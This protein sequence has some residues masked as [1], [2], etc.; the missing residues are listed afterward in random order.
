[1]EGLRV[2]HGGKTAKGA[3][4]SESELREMGIEGF[5]DGDE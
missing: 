5:E 2:F 3:G 1:M 4:L